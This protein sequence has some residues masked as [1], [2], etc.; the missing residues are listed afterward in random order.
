MINE[1]CPLLKIFEEEDF[2][3]FYYC[4]KDNCFIYFCANDCIMNINEI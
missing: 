1:T 2:Q 4:K 3:E